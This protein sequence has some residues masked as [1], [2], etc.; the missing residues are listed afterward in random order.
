[1]ENQDQK[2]L[3]LTKLLSL[4][5]AKDERGRLENLREILNEVKFSSE[6]EIALA[7]KLVAEAHII[8]LDAEPRD[9]EFAASLLAANK[10]WPR[11][12]ELE[13]LA[14]RHGYFRLAWKIYSFGE[15]NNIKE[16]FVPGFQTWF[17]EFGLLWFDLFVDPRKNVAFLH[18]EDE[19]IIGD[20]IRRCF[21]RVSF[22]ENFTH[23]LNQKAIPEVR[24]R[25]LALLAQNQPPRIAKDEPRTDV[26]KSFRAFCKAS[27]LEIL[28]R[29]QE[30]QRG[31][32]CSSFVYLVRDH[33]GI[34]KIFKEL[35]CYE[36][37]RLENIAHNETLV[38]ERLK[39]TSDVIIPCLGI[40]KI[41]EALTF[42]KLPFNFA[43]Q[44]TPLI[45]QGKKLG[46]DAACHLVS[47]I[48][49][50]LEKVHECDVLH[51]DL[52]PENITFDGLTAR[53][54]DFGVSK[55]LARGE[56]E[57]DIWLADPRYGTPEC[58]RNF[59]AGKT[60]DIFQLG[61]IFHQLLTGNHP[62]AA[63]DL[64]EDERDRENQ[65]LKYFWPTTVLHYEENLAGVLGDSRLSIL[66]RML[67]KNPSSRPNAKEVKEFLAKGISSQVSVTIPGP[68]QNVRE[69]N[70]IL[71]PARMG[72]PH[73]GHIEY[74]ARL[75]KMG[76]YVRISL[77]RSFTITSRDPLPKWIVAKMVARSLLDLGI[78]PENFEF[79]YTPFY[80]TPEKMRLHFTFAPNVE[81]I[82]AV[83][84]SNPSV[85]AL[86]PDLPLFDQKTVFGKD[87][88]DYEDLSWGE[89]LRESVRGGDY[90]TFNQYAASGVGQI[91][92]FEELREELKKP[93]LDF[94]PGAIKVKLLNSA[95]DEIISSRFYKY[96][97]PEKSLAR[98]LISCGTSCE[99][100]DPYAKHTRV[101]INSTQYN[102]EY[103]G[104]SLEGST[105]TIIYKQ[106]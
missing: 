20:I 33:D 48:A 54:F 9:A 52:K 56:T 100:I 36:N 74:I 7:R 104:T 32:K 23:G 14:R 78:S 73:K 61:L 69:K 2:A 3:I 84:S 86:L 102:W 55:I 57:T 92:T 6:D 80:E 103:Y 38:F 1:M 66:P 22:W 28:R 71:F 37:T 40:C 106:T 47:K 62:F 88:E 53:L 30:G 45:T 21:G 58:G 19:M 49:A 91:M 98:H 97:S 90:A 70:T 59:V 29:M 12:K 72:I 34:I 15:R 46:A 10:D 18:P 82:T 17:S 16:L 35:I 94:T 43:P 96:S 76:F 105:L 64:I 77:Q 24:K 95:E 67:E 5:S 63:P 44:I 81:D 89:I 65:I 31:A 79:I 42:M 27:G 87:G 93:G 68:A 11:L 75:I 13:I 4:L 50:A 83:A 51:L 25:I 39:E 99:I 60:S 101:L 8:S 85:E 26:D 41:D